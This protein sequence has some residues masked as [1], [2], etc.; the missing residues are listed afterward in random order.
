MEAGL[1][2]LYMDTSEPI[3]LKVSAKLAVFTCG[4]LILTELVSI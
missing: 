1:A 2:F 3:A 4:G